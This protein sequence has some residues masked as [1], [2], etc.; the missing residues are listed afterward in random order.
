MTNNE[1]T[2]TQR[3]R[4]V[5][6]IR[7][8]GGFT[9]ATAVRAMNAGFG[10]HPAHYIPFVLDAVRDTGKSAHDRDPYG[11]APIVLA[12]AITHNVNAQS[13]QLAVEKYA[14]EMDAAVPT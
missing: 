7:A 8:D 3:V 5:Q 4:A 1:P 12:V 2:H 10:E 13:L 14:D 6:A 11:V 9:L